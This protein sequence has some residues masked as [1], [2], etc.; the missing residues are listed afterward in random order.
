MNLSLMSGFSASNRSDSSRA[1]VIC[2]LDTIAIC[3]RVA[4]GAEGA[5]ARTPRQRQA[6]G[7]HHANVVRIGLLSLPTSFLLRSQSQVHS[8]VAPTRKRA[9]LRAALRA[10]PVLGGTTVSSTVDEHRR[11]SSRGTDTV[12]SCNSDPPRR[13][14]R[15]KNRPR[16]RRPRREP[17]ANRASGVQK[18]PS[19]RVVDVDTGPTGRTSSQWRSGGLQRSR[20]ARIF[21]QRR[22]SLRIGI[23][24]RAGESVGLQLFSAFSEHI[25]APVW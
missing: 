11:M 18:L 2:E 17:Q 15:M 8:Y 19:N 20:D 6:R 14:P 1:S 21:A 23:Q 3:D 16:S 13:R 12:R 9:K 4:R 24:R 22:N 7:G 5:C 10:R 25:S